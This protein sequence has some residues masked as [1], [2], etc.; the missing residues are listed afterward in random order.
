MRSD[1]VDFLLAHDIR[2]LTFSIQNLHSESMVGIIIWVRTKLY[3]E[4]E[5]KS[6][7]K[8]TKSLCRVYKT[9]V[10]PSSVI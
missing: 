7:A 4:A 8:E 10:S 5:V 9:K 6:R 1:L 3:R 2:E